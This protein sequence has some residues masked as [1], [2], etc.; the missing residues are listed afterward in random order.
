MADREHPL[1]PPA[2]QGPALHQSVHVQCL[3]YAVQPLVLL[4][5]PVVADYML[6]LAKGPGG[7]GPSIGP[8]SP[9][10]VPGTELV[11]VTHSPGLPQVTLPQHISSGQALRRAVANRGGTWNLG[12]P[13]AAAPVGIWPGQCGQLVER[14][15][16]A[17]CVGICMEH[18]GG[19]CVTP[20]PVLT[21]EYWGQQGWGFSSSSLSSQDDG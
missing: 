20:K 16:F 17:G 6:W 11:A 9:S 5:G 18:T 14:S 4:K 10:T 21:S 13:N 3:K 8:S 19:R 1:L 15:C 12:W 2:V 7:P